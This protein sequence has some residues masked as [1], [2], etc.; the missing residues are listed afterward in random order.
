MARRCSGSARSPARCS[1]PACVTAFAFGAASNSIYTNCYALIQ[2]QVGPQRAAIATGVL[3]TIYF[4][5]AAFS[6]PILVAARNAMGWKEGGVVVFGVAY[7][8]GAIAI[9]FVKHRPPGRQP[10]QDAGVAAG[11]GTG[12]AE[13][14]A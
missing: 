13:K 3:A 1:W 10:V 6:G 9:T 14:S 11:A 5:L 2:E 4:L 8:V 12:V 7:A